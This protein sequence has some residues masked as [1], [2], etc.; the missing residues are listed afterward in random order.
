[1]FY[2]DSSGN[3]RL[4][5]CEEGCGHLG[6][7]NMAVALTQEELCDLLYLFRNAIDDI[8]EGSELSQ[9]QLHRDQPD[10]AVP[11]RRMLRLVR[12]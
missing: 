7:G 2:A 4:T 10:M 6:I 5:I 12:D 9:E 3:V 1:M 11:V 8:A